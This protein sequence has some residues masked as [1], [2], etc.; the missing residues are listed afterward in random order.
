MPSLWLWQGIPEKGR[1]AD[2]HSS[3]RPSE[4]NWKRNWP[5]KDVRRAV[6]WETWG[7]GG[8]RKSFLVQ[9]VSE[10]YS[11]LSLKPC[12][13]L[14]LFPWFLWANQS[15]NS[16]CPSFHLFY[17]LYAFWMTLRYWIKQIFFPRSL[18]RPPDKSPFLQLISSSTPLPEQLL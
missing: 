6:A 12:S 7:N 4:W 3:H 15:L 18:Q 8:K 16:T 17:I 10:F 13:H 11:H 1:V 9:I 5:S 14:L 2:L